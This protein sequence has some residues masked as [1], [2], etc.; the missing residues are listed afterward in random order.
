MPTSPYNTKCGHL[1]CK[2]PRS[3]LNS[4]CLDHGGKESLSRDYDA[5][6]NTAAWRQLRTAQLSRHPLCQACLV[7]GKVTLALHVDH[8]FPWRKFGE[9][10][11]KRNILQSLCQ[12]HHSYKTG[13]EQRGIY[14]AYTDK[15]EQFTDDDYARIVAERLG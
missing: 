12:P 14:E 10:A 2:N 11:F 9:Q 7:E 15:V 3:K 13:L 1:G 4:Y 6:Y 5:I 8:V